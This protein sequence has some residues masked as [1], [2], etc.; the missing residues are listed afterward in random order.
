ML[1][2]EEILPLVEKPSRYTG[3]ELN[4]VVKDP[5]TVDIRYAFIFPDVYEIGMS[6]LGIKL[7]YHII[8]N[9]EDAYCERVYSPWPDM[10]KLMVENNIPLSSLETGTPLNKFDIIGITVQYEMCYTNMIN[11]LRLGNVP[12]WS[13]DRGEDDPIVTCGGPC[14]YNPEPFADF[15]DIISIG[16]GE[17]HMNELL[18]LLKEKKKNNWSRK[19]FL[20]RASQIEG[21]YVPSLYNVEYTDDGFI[22]SV[23]P[24]NDAPKLVKKRIIEDFDNV[25]Y[26]DNIIVPYMS[27]VHDRI[28]LEIM[29]G[30]T[31]GCRFCQAG[32]IYRPIREKSIDKL[33]EI[34]KKLYDS[35]GY[36]EISL[37]SLSSSDYSQI[38]EL[39]KYLT[40]EYT[41][42]GVSIA[43][44]SL[45]VDTIKNTEFM[46]D[47]ASFRKAGLTFAPEAGTQR[48]RDVVN[49]GVVEED[50][51]IACEKA[52]DA[53]WDSVK[54]YF[55]IGLPTETLD[56]V[57]GIAALTYNVKEMYFA[58]GKK[59][60]KLN[61]SVSA[62]TFVP[63]PCTPF[64]WCGQ[65][66]PEN[67]I[68]KQ[69]Y[70]KN[71]L[72]GRGLHF[73]WNDINLSMLEAVF[74]R[75]DR[76]LSK[77]LA[78]AVELGCHMDAWDEHF[79]MD[80]WKQ[81]FE[82]TGI[83]YKWYASVNYDLDAILPWDHIDCGVS[84][85]FLKKEFIKAFKGETTKDCREGCNACGLTRY[86][87]KCREQLKKTASEADEL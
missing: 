11:A 75:G 47:L 14:T 60:G 20:I 73:S 22:K 58:K 82:E 10:E 57:E 8:N 29:R 41:Q 37:C 76:R 43:L 17:E 36:E 54:L 33:K 15:F 52:F 65:D 4:M 38:D 32:M 71:R 1:T 68:E 25:Y 16:E 42:K 81:A 51:M 23:E 63:K 39:I 24:T 70:L 49:K 45:R 35:T 53:G 84:K 2:F 21:T 6:H 26:P 18:D 62:S 79:N 74:A 69:E 66:I 5:S 34:T 19:E 30:C 72:K 80:L 44:P 28:T 50:L 46:S 48:L 13:K 77:A 59:K 9:R 61:I 85:T 78:R 87:A 3:N 40:D 56:D 12:I 27:I 55:M 86:S 7:L 67:V 83:D 31:R 64:Q